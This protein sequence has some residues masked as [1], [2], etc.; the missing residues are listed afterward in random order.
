M[1]NS[2]NLNT[3][4]RTKKCLNIYIPRQLQDQ[5]ARKQKCKYKY[6]GVEGY[7]KVTADQQHCWA[8]PQFERRKTV[9]YPSS[10]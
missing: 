3:T 1:E 9:L 4:V 2:K 5:L 10:L 7:V 8:W 6:T